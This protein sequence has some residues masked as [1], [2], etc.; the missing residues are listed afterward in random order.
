MK[1]WRFMDFMPNPNRN[2]I[3]DWYDDLSKQAQADFVTLISQLEVLKDWAM[4]EFRPLRGR[5]FK[6]LGELRFKTEKRNHRVIGFAANNT[7][8]I[9]LIGCFHKEA[10][11]P[12]DALETAIKRKIL[13]ESGE[14]RMC[15]HK[16]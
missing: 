1:L 7:D 4:P 6:G 5:K 8:Y 10:Y 12:R 13:V 11:T 14:G 2:A 15:E 3:K 9:L 16:V